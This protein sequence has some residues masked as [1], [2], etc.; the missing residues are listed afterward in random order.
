MEKIIRKE[1]I[2]KTDEQDFR[3]F[4]ELGHTLKEWE[5]KE[6]CT[7]AWSFPIEELFNGAIEPQEGE[8]YWLI[9]ERLYE[10]YC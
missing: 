10:T 1:V 4:I 3:F 5:E 7:D 6:E 9:D 8:T 2:I